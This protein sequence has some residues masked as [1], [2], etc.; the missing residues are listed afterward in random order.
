[1]IVISKRVARQAKAN[2]FK[3][4]VLAEKAS[5]SALFA[6]LSEL[7]GPEG[8]GIFDGRQQ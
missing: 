7:F 4:V 5:D 1:L 8:H 2:G 6:A 3:K